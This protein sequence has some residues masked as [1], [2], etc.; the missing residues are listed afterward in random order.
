MKKYK[1]LLLICLVFII[2]GCSFS[3]EVNKKSINNDI[4]TSN[5]I[6]IPDVSGMTEKDASSILELNGFEIGEIYL[7][8]SSNYEEGLVVKAEASN[9]DMVNLYVATNSDYEMEDFVGEDYLEVKTKLEYLG[10]DVLVKEKSYLTLYDDFTIVEQ[11]PRVGT[12]L[13]YGDKIILY[14][15][16]IEKLDLNESN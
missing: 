5:F 13:S 12:I 1:Y 10:L 15:P 9:E 4:D 14:I 6:I 11:E 7:I 8:A 2:T 16:K 3:V